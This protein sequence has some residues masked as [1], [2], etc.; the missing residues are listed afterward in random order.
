MT[1][2]AT[3]ATAHR[4]WDERWRTPGGRAGWIEPEP[5]VLSTVR[6]LGVHR[7]LDLGC[8]VGRHALEFARMGLRVTAVDRSEAG[9]AWLR[10]EAGRA[11]LAVDARHADFTRLP[12]PAGAFDYVLSWNVVYHGDEE[13]L[14]AV[15]AE[16]RR[17]LRPGGFYQSTMLSKRSPGFDTG[18]RV[19]PNTF[20]RPDA[21]DDKKHPH[22]YQDD[23][24]VLRTHAG[25]AVLEMYDREHGAPGSYHWHL[26][27]E[28]AP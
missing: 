4:H 11:G 7:V 14:G 21:G 17:V 12:Y 22:L 15:L 26:L 27:F 1:S 28:A 2:D 8:G 18:V 9:L 25:L 19:G 13:T 10:G 24:D 16:V 23:R 20:V 6:R 5:W 3:P